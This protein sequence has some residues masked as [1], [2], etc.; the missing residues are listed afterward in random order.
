[1]G[2]KD[3]DQRES[4]L[5]RANVRYRAGYCQIMESMARR[6]WTTDVGGSVEATVIGARR[7]GGDGKKIRNGKKG[8]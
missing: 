2:V 3:S 6:E 7:S 1:M 5:Y 4:V 8:M